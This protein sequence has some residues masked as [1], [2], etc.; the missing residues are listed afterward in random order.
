MLLVA[1]DFSLSANPLI[2]LRASELGDS[3]IQKCVIDALRD[4]RE[5]LRA[6]AVE[7]LPTLKPNLHKCLSGERVLN[8]KA[9]DVW[10]TLRIEG[11]KVGKELFPGTMVTVFQC[12]S[13][14]SRL[15]F[16]EAL[17]NAGFES[18]DGAHRSLGTPLLLLLDPSRLGRANSFDLIAWFLKKQASPYFIANHSFPTA[19]FYLAIE[20]DSLRCDSKFLRETL[21]LVSSVCDPLY[22]DDCSCFC[23]SRGGCLVAHK[24]W[25]CDPHMPNHDTCLPKSRAILSTRLREWLQFAQV[26]E[27]VASV[28]YGEMC[29][30]EIFDRLGLAHTC[31]TVF[32]GFH[33]KR[34]TF[35][36]EMRNELHEEDAVLSEQ[37]KLI[38]EEYGRLKGSYPGTKLEFWERWWAR[39][40][41]IL[42]ELS[43]QER[44][45]CHR[46]DR[47]PRW[48]NTKFTGDIQRKIRVLSDL[49]AAAEESALRKMGYYGWEFEDVIRMHLQHI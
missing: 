24:L 21:P 14:E 34:K 15:E 28:Y 11:I 9:L 48:C 35:D 49:R 8:A 5:Q 23:S 32:E 45:R 27:A 3:V 43:P 38:L 22:T 20:Y 4:R 31:C 12:V 13:S 18:I 33:I 1:K 26:D 25:S 36:E 40:D 19:L 41:M 29:R 10:N 6:M 37:L 47:E 42:P 16:L 39:L 2:M 46:P 30:L 17:Y 7:H 44:C